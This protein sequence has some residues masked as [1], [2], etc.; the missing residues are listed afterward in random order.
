MCEE[1]LSLL[2]PALNAPDSI[3]VDATLGL[4]GHSLAALTRFDSLTIIGIDRDPQALDMARATLSRFGDRVETHQATYDQIEEI[5]QGR[6][7]EA[8]LFDLGLSSL[9]IDSKERG[10]AY[11]ADAPLSMRMDGNDSEL[12]AADVVNTYTA[13]ELE[14]IFR[15]YGDEKYARRIAQAIVSEREREPFSTSARLVDVILSAVP[16]R[17]TRSGH[18]A[19]RPFQAIRMEVNQERA[20]LEK[21]LPDA[22]N[23]LKVDGRMAVLSYHSGEDR[24][25]KRVFSQAHTDHVPPGVPIVPQEH[26]AKFALVTRGALKPSQ[27]DAELN[28]RAKPARLRV[29]TRI[30]EDK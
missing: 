26:R 25:V 16:V 21:A 29:I 19:K 30:E 3:M 6:R 27:E 9:Q 15:I 20:I 1:I 11:A 14:W 17:D 18:P 22:L 4:G 7:V 28:P 13:A 5:L 8:V 10:F 12:T 23:V 24:L 2:A